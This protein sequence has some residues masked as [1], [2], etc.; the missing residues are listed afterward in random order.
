LDKSHR[1]AKEL[2]GMFQGMVLTWGG[3]CPLF[4]SS[5]RLVVLYKRLAKSWKGSEEWGGRGR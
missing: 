4:L 3:T 2:G 1:H 5:C